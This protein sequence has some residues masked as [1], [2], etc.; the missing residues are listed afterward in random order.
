MTFDIKKVL[1]R[2]LN[3]GLK[4]RNIRYGVGAALLLLSVFMGNIFILIIGGVLV[5]TAYLRWCPAYS[6]MSM[7]TVKEGEE[8]TS[9]CCHGHH[10]GDEKAA[11]S[12]ESEESKET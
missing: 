11:E 9:G 4:D 3:V 7:N 10:H 2:E 8:A 6:G 12:T 5:A 1:K